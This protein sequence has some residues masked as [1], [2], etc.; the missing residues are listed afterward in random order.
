MAMLKTPYG[1]ML[2]FGA[3]ALVVMPL[4]KVD[5]EEYKAMVEEKNRLADSVTGRGRGRDP[6][7]RGAGIQG[8]RR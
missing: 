3:F 1:I 5:P 6:G 7:G 4:L 8:A 2:A